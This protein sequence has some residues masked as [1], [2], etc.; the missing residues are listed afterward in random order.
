M[1]SAKK[2]AAARQRSKRQPAV[3]TPEQIA[4]LES[5]AANV[6][7]RRVERGLSQAKLAEA[8]ALDL[9]TVQR[10]ERGALDIHVLVLDALARALSAT[11]TELM[12]PARLLPPTR[13]RPPGRRYLAG[14]RRDE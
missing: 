3:R 10:V 2:R 7:R 1:A 6:R 8:T 12:E 9:T 11:V 5:I 13:G 4:L 14:A